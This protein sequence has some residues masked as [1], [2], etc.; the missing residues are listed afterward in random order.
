MSLFTNKRFVAAGIGH[1][2]VDVLNGVRNVLLAFLSVPLGLTNTSLATIGMVYSIVAAVV[3]PFA[4]HFS[5]RH[6]RRWISAF[7]VFWM[8]FF[9]CLAMIIPGWP[10]LILFIIASVG[11]GIFHPVGTVEATLIGQAD[12]NGHESTATSIY[13]FFGQ[14]G[15]FLGPILAGAILDA[16]G[17]RGLFSLGLLGSLTGFYIL[18]AYKNVKVSVEEPEVSL[19]P[20]AQV[21]NKRVWWYVAIL[22]IVITVDS[23]AGSNMS[24]FIPKYLSD[25]GQSAST[26]G[27]LASL[28]IGAG[29]FGNVFGGYL[30]DRIARHKVIMAGFIIACI[31][32][33]F[34]AK[35]GY[36]LW[37]YL[38][39][40]IAG[41]T[42]GSVYSSLIIMAQKIFP[43]R[44]ALA[45]GL[46][47]GFM[48][49]SGAIGALISGVMADKLG[50]I[51]VFYLTAGMLLVSGLL[52]FFLN[53]KLSHKA[54]VL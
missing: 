21:E 11:S 48:F 1:F 15:F 45:S 46:V 18:S 39:L 52:A 10:G 47:L 50:V 32:I 22:I 53:S 33:F 30:A 40:P 29:A 35:T 9:F 51:S 14:F 6:G 36:S 26:Y 44:M 24:L 54:P 41:F 8:V 38:L 37:Y 28:Y 20:V 5:D 23:W 25:L 12:G 31:P 27:L 13:F 2:T 49:A 17:Q 7:G 16:W 4:G 42:V 19:E 34:I 3:Q 43:G